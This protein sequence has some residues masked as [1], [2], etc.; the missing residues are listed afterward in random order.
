MQA[1]P[2][3]GKS[4]ATF[5]DASVLKKRKKGNIKDTP[6]TKVQIIISSF[7]N[8]SYKGVIV[9]HLRDGASVTLSERANARVKWCYYF[10]ANVQLLC[11]QKRISE[12]ES[13]ER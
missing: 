10:I 5:T 4:H 6:S 13:C 9:A 2:K 7:L 3:S 1:R 12:S 8:Q 11:I